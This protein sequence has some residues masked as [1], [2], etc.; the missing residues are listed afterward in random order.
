[1]RDAGN[2][3]QGYDMDKMIAGLKREGGSF[4]LFGGEALLMPLPDLETIFDFGLKTYGSNGVQT[5]GTLITDAHYDLFD[6]Y[7]VSVGMSLDGPGEL[8]DS[9]WIKDLPTTRAATAK[10]MHALRTLAQRGHPPSVIVTLYRG[11][12]LGE[13]LDR[14]IEWLSEI[15]ALGVRSVRLHLLEV[16]S[17]HVADTMAMSVDENVTALLKLYEFQ[18]RTQIQFD[19]FGEMARLLLGNDQQTTCIWNACDPY[20]TAAVRGVDGQ[21]ESSN[22]GRTNKDGVNWLKSN[23]VG[24]ERQL[25]LYQTPQSDLGC[26]DCRFFF[27]CKGQCPGT[28]EHGDWRNRSEHCAIWMALFERIEADLQGL[29][30]QP[31]SKASWRPKLE[32]VMLETWS[33]GRNISIRDAAAQARGLSMAK[34]PCAKPA[35]PPQRA[36]NTD[37]DQEHGDHWD[38]PDGTQHSDGPLEI[39][40]DGGRTD[41]HGDS[42]NE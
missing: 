14:L 13:R 16:E 17:A 3:T 25:A 21:G 7:K 34:S 24:H 22:C 15:E 1:M 9:R 27:A 32:R 2:I 18:K 11:N 40:G 5:N 29:G 23:R 6:K 4:A 35:L 28:A 33:S 39:H 19:L 37:D 31:I 36:A 12:A 41:M 30:Q 38:A 10:S 8:N 26:K 20:T 42:G